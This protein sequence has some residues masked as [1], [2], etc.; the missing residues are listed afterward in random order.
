MKFK[1]R[2]FHRYLSLT[3]AA[4]WLLQATTGLLLVF[5]W[6]LDDLGL[7]GP[8]RALDPPRFAATLQRLQAER[9]GERVTGVYPSGGLPGRFDVLVSNA[10]GA[11]DVVR[12]DG[13][14]A[15]LRQRPWNY[16][17]LHIGW[18]Q[19]ATYLHQTL[20]MHTTGNW[21][22]GLSGLLL[23]TN[24]GVGLSLAWPRAGQ[25]LRVLTPP[26]NGHLAAKLY[27]WH[28]AVGLWLAIPALLLVSAGVVRAYD[29][30]LADYFENTRPPPTEAE[31][32]REP[33]S[34]SVSV[35]EVL[36]T[37][38]KL[39][40]GSQL[41]ALEFPDAHSPWFKVQVTQ[42][43]DLRRASGTT[44]IYVSSRSGRVLGNY[45]FRTLP[46]KTRL[47]DA[48]Y[49][50]HTGEIGGVAGR[51]VTALIGLWLLTMIGLGVSLWWK[52]RSASA[53]RDPKSAP[54]AST[55]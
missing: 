44:S 51:C 47:W 46:M 11:T 9:P 23:L 21:I 28:R 19:V 32:A 49:P 22:I 41:A 30:P 4:L 26:R 12:I 13:A 24:I 42:A 6:E 52:R 40:P 39:Y 2:I 20:F 54:S 10:T 43:H 38:L 7:P 25:W 14:G 35:A 17:F 15:V 36:Q 3:M 37:A 33:A 45:D 5:H 53:A 48:V 29:D 27:G 34:A 1:L 8:A 16:D 31:A 18:L 55:R 50:F